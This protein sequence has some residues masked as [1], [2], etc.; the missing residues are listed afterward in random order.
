M[1]PL[2][3]PSDAAKQRWTNL[4]RTQ[5]AINA[6][7][8]AIVKKT[9]AGLESGDFPNAWAEPTWKQALSDAQD[10]LCIWCTREPRA[11][12]S[13][14]AV[15][16][17]RPKSEVHRD[18]TIDDD[19]QGK[20]TRHLLPK[21]PT[22]PKHGLRPGYHW[23]AYDPD[24]HAFICETC[25]GRKSS[26]WP[27]EPW[28]DSATWKAPTNPP[29]EQ[30]LILD[31]FDESFDPLTHFEFGDNGTIFAKPRD[32]KADATILM[33]G[34]DE[35]DVNES[36]QKVYLKLERQLGTLVRLVRNP[37]VV[38]DESGIVDQVA[39]SCDWPSPHAAFYRA[40][41]HKLLQSRGCSWGQLADLWQRYGVTTTIS[42][43]PA[44]SWR[45]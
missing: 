4:R 5:N 38:A 11:G 1:R 14:G 40:A 29:N 33:A 17:L 2:E 39:E 9:A 22:D 32:A 43:P 24:N 20:R 13:H 6:V 23:L 12:G 45:A 15:D 27:V 30:E 31:P 37:H 35:Q 16:H 21:D 42:E 26:F 41:L 19:G 36:R 7:N 34:L 28:H 3:R 25:N 8:T 44:N 10:G 18:V